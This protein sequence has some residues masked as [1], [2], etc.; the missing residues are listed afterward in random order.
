MTNDSN[1]SNASP[2]VFMLAGPTCSGKTALSLLLAERLP[3]EII[4]VD[5]TQVYRGL[6]IGA[7]K[8]DR[9]TR[10]RIP[11]HLIDVR[12]PAQ[13]YDAGAFVGDVERLA[14][15]IV[16]RGRWPLLVGGTMLY[17]R[18]LLVGLAN[19]PQADAAV[20]AQI[21][22][23]AALL[24]WAVLHSQLAQVDPEAAARIHRNDPQRIQ[25]ALEVYRL[26][27]R[28]ISEW[29]QLS[30]QPARLRVL[31][32][33]ALMPA[34]RA[35]LHQ[36]IEQRFHD[37]LG[38]GFLDEVRLL[39]ARPD[40]HA[41][42]P[43]MRSVGYR[44]FWELLQSSAVPGAEQIEQAMQASIAATRQ[45]ARRQLTWINADPGWRILSIGATKDLENAADTLALAV[46]AAGT[47]C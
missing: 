41:D 9:E 34:D 46:T 44:Q 8:P 32:R 30:T 28:P 21:D 20:R 10:A 15:E 16:A 31:G 27:G 2:G 17:Y 4:S 26:S 29:Q 42:L 37:M 40:L 43:A 45:L 19:L 36:R 47:P 35:P 18:A 23:E 13:P 14:A 1:A 39:R 24:G 38:A 22:S 3:I 5:S 6:D 33:W 25:R 7:A 11:H 12:D